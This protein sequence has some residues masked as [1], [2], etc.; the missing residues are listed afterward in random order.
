MSTS[1]LAWPAALGARLSPWLAR[2]RALAPRERQA[3]AL[4]ASLVALFA[5]WTLAV[6]PA[7]RIVREAPA[8]LDRLDRQLQE[9]Q[10]LAAEA[11]DLRATPPLPPAQG[12]AALQAATSRLGDRARLNLVGDRATVTF[13]G[14]EAGRLREWLSEVRVGARAQPIEAQLTRS[15]PGFNGS[16]VLQLSGVGGGS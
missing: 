1:R 9:M 15:G 11:K 16:V 6:A 7:W 2:W 13:N 12:V 4:A 8:E 3:V 5:A 10:R 14:I